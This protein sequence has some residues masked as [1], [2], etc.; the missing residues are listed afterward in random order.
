MNSNNF[1][2]VCVCLYLCVL[3]VEGNASNLELRRLFLPIAHLNLHRGCKP[4]TD[5]QI[6]RKANT[7][8]I[9]ISGHAKIT[10]WENASKM[11]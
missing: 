4:S 2:A 6:P 11:P 9:I 3:I 5:L 7:T 10:E 1:H 8:E